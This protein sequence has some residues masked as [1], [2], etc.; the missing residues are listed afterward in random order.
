MFEKS[1][2]IEAPQKSENKIKEN[3]GNNEK[4]NKKTSNPC[5]VGCRS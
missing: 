3:P 4:L 5:E 2:K 1:V